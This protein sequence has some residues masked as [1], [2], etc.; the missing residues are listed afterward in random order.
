MCLGNY[1]KIPRI[2]IPYVLKSYSIFNVKDPFHSGIS[3]NQPITRKSPEITQNIGG[4]PEIIQRY[5]SWALTVRLQ[6][7]FSVFSKGFP[8]IVQSTHSPG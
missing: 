1:D 4:S 7:L 8:G 2:S 3:A 6:P 5:N